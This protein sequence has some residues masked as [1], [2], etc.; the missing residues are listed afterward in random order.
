ME[1]FDSRFELDTLPRTTPTSEN[2]NL[3]FSDFTL[4]SDLR[5]SDFTLESD[6]RWMDSL[7]VMTLRRAA[8]VSLLLAS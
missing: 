1:N 6:L 7:Q 8:R 2:K 4:E 5:F 3:A